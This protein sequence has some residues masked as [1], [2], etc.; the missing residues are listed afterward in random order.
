MDKE[1]LI[2]K[3]E[4]LQKALDA[5]L[6]IACNIEFPNSRTENYFSAVKIALNEADNALDTVRI[7]F[8]KNGG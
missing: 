7:L 1:P 4:M 6:D 5:T 8:N 2:R 3:L